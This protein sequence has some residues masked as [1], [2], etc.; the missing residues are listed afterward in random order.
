MQMFKRNTILKRFGF[1]SCDIINLQKSYFWHVKQMK[2]NYN[3]QTTNKNPREKW[4]EEKKRGTHR[5]K[6]QKKVLEIMG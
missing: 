4:E 6:S 5:R 2:S 3:R 1:D